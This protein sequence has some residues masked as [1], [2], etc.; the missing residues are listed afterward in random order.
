MKALIGFW[1]FVCLLYLLFGDVIAA[2]AIGSVVYGIGWLLIT[3]VVVSIG[4][5]AL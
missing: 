1:V 4:R 3:A 5:K 2:F